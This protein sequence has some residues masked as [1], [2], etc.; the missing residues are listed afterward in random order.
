MKNLF[1]KSA[2]NEGIFFLD[3][4]FSFLKIYFKNKNLKLD[5]KKLFGIQMNKFFIFII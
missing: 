2:M 3:F 1:S 5:L 4:L